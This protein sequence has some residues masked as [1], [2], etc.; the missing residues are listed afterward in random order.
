MEKARTRAVLPTSGE[1]TITSSLPLA[2]HVDKVLYK[3]VRAEKIVHRDIKEA[4]DLRG[5]KVH[6]QH[7]V[8]PRW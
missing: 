8:A 2:E 7:S 5:V 4:L 6:R 3:Q 1:T